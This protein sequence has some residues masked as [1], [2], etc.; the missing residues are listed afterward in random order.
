MIFKKNVFKERKLSTIALNSIIKEL[1][2][3]NDICFIKINRKF[4]EI[5][6]EYGVENFAK[7]I[8]K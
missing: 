1:I 2:K 6:S 8:K 7:F 4:N 3:N 5:G